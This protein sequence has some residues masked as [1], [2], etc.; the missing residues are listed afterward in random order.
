[1]ARFNYFYRI[2][3]V[4]NGNY[5]YGVH[6]TSNLE[7]GY[8]GSGRR[9]LYAIK[10]YGKENFKKEILLFF[11][12]YEKALDYEAE[13]VNEQ[14]LLDPSCYNLALG[15][16]SDVGF[17][18]KGPA[19]IDKNTGELIK[20]KDIEEYKFLYNTGNYFGHTKG[21]GLYK[22]DE[23]KVYCISKDDKLI[24]ELNLHGIHHNKLMCKDENGHV[25]WINK[26]DERYLSGTLTLF[27]QNKN[28]TEETKRK[29][30][31]KNSIAQQGI[32]N[33][34]FGTCWITNGIDSKKINKNDLIP[35]GWQR[36]RKMKSK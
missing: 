26:D 2:E 6:K 13:I 4:I 29:I 1:M 22:A 25:F 5:Y 19:L 21:K 7:D 34:Q 18:R 23:G 3:N 24:Y 33:S 28:H 15:G 35:K 14:L 17:L 27:W 12:T 9:I 36:G 11:D 10:K 30:G 16:K 20:P 8:L 32:K 31:Q